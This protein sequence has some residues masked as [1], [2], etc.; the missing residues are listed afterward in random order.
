[1]S[2]LNSL[3]KGLE[4]SI[5]LKSITRVSTPVFACARLSSWLTLV[6]ACI[7]TARAFI[8]KNIDCISTDA[9]NQNAIN[10]YCY[11]NAVFTL[12]KA[13][14][15]EVPPLTDLGPEGGGMVHP[16]PGVG[17]Q[18]ED[19]D[20][21]VHAYYQWVPF[22]LV[23]QAILLYVPW[24]LWKAQEKGYLSLVVGNMDKIHIGGVDPQLVKS[25]ASFF[26]EHMGRH[27]RYAL[28]CLA[29]EALGVFLTIGNIFFTNLFLGGAFLSY[30]SDTFQ[31]LFRS[32]FDYSLENPLHRVF[33][34]VSNKILSF[35]LLP[36]S[37][38]VRHLP[39]PLQVLVRLQPR[40]SFL[41]FAFLSYGSD[42]FQYLFRS[43]F[44]YSLEN[45][46]HRVFPKIAK[47]TWRVYG[48]SGSIQVFDNMCV[49]PINIANEKIYAFLWLVYIVLACIATL[50]FVIHLLFVI[51]H[52]CRVKCLKSLLRIQHRTEE[53]CLTRLLEMDSSY[54][55]W[56]VVQHVQRHLIYFKEWSQAVVEA[57][58]K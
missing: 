33:P 51:S 31:Y 11:I 46:L 26:V 56:F 47:C 1:M 22:V 24:Y 58:M 55:H 48:P 15:F 32:S 4:K 8:G 29:C 41:S 54:G 19:Q 42:T 3:F 13:E 23:L 16:H 12:P 30:G 2:K 18:G 37:L 20:V 52:V 49:L 9:N 50:S 45:P 35:F 21:V 5:P 27:R 44:D 38:R 39:V 34:K 57:K 6:G 7:V 36:S 17:P 25:S 10:T 14:N 28:M 53:S 43:S 40:S